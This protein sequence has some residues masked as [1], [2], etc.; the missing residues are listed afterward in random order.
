MIVEHLGNGPAYDDYLRRV[1]ERQELLLQ[2]CRS[3]FNGIE[4]ISLEIGCGHGHWLVAYASAHRD[5][6]CVGIDLK[7]KRVER[8]TRKAQRS[9]LDN[10]YFLKAEAGE[11]LQALPEGLRIERVFM[12]FPDPWPKKR[13]HK[14][15]LIQSNFLDMLQERTAPGAQLCFRTDHRPY[16]Q[17][18]VEHIDAHPAWQIQQGAPWPFENETFFQKILKRYSSLVAL[19]ETPSK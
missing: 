5:E 3:L 11:F 4:C 9:R 19:R 17:W 2:T 13:H 6:C 8:A 14:N 16:F 15:R 18:A 12:I 7:T 10:L 1:R